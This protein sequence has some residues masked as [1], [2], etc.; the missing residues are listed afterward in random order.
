[1]MAISSSLAPKTLE[2]ECTTRPIRIDGDITRRSLIHLDNGPL[3]TLH[4]VPIIGILHTARYEVQYASHLRILAKLANRGCLTSRI[5]SRESVDD[6]IGVDIVA[7]ALVSISVQAVSLIDA[8][9]D[10]VDTLLW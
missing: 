3:Q 7:S 9:A 2:F 1:M 10:M 5:W 4:S 6:V 8:C